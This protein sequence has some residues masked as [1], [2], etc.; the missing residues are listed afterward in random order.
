MK[1]HHGNIYGITGAALRPGSGHQGGGGAD[2][3]G[4][5]EIPAARFCSQ[6]TAH[7]QAY[8]KMRNV[9]I[10]AFSIDRAMQCRTKSDIHGC[11]G[12]IQETI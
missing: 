1:S 6:V 7:Y 5:N 3:R 9:R 10:V 8:A 11:S 2:G 12:P 4:T